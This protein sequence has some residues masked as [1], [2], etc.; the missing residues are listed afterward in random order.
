MNKQRE[1]TL[2]AILMSSQ[3]GDESIAGARMIHADA[4]SND[5]VTALERDG[6]VTREGGLVRLTATGQELAE[7][8]VRRHR[9]TEVL[10]STVLGLGA[11][12]ASDIA[13]QLEHDVRPEMV[14]A[15]CTLLGHP[16]HCPHGDP[17]PQGPCCRAGQ[18]VVESPVVPL[19]AL[20]VGDRGRVVYI[21]PRSHQRLQRLMSLG[22][23]P[24]VIVT[25]T[26]RRPAVCLRFEET[27]LAIDRD[28]AEDIQV[29]R[30]PAE[31]LLRR[32]PSAS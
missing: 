12:R 4:V 28:V 26:R 16:K 2:E 20:S 30:V 23:N 13:C 24:G 15:V 11:E 32:S 7:D 27:E 18:T 5:D 21:R 31:E 9:L 17:I 22:L 8:V 6:L 3:R 14:G 29:S 25:L 19:S 10:L 1:H